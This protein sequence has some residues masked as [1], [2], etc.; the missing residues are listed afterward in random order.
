[1]NSVRTNMWL[2]RFV[3]QL[4]LPTGLLQLLPPSGLCLT[5][6]FYVVTTG[7]INRLLQICA[8]QIDFMT[9]INW[10]STGA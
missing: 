2:V 5:V 3:T 1:M 6:R 8:G 4:S 9:S 10:R 7:Y